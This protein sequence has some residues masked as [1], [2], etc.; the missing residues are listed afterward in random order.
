MSIWNSEDSNLDVVD[1]FSKVAICL[2]ARAHH[3]A[4]CMDLSCTHQFAG[5]TKAPLC[6]AWD[7][8]VFHRNPVESIIYFSKGKFKKIVF[9][10]PG[11][12]ELHWWRSGFVPHFGNGRSK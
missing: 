11:G 1:F 10:I 9:C 2:S 7:V 12:I 6:T 8:K 5:Q 3:K 4:Y